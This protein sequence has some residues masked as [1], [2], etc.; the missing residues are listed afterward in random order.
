MWFGSL[1]N[2]VF[3]WWGDYVWEWVREGNKLFTKS[4]VKS[5]TK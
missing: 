1:E 3:D 5:L 4:S 2:C